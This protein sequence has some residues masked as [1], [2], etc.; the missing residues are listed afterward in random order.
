MLDHTSSYNEHARLSRVKSLII[1]KS[2]VLGDVNDEASFLIGV[3][4][5]DVTDC[6]IS[7]GWSMDRDVIFPA[8]IVNALLVV[9]LFAHSVDDHARRP[10]GALLFLLFVHLLNDGD[11]E[12]FQFAII[13]IRDNQVSNSV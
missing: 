8:P 9:D 5:N 11:H 6:A 7:Q 1:Q 3:E 13:H 4:V 10:D 2:N 12:R